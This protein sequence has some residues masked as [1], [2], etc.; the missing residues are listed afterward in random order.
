M[1]SP[2]N[3]TTQL[4]GSTIHKQ[5][6][7]LINSTA[8]VVEMKLAKAEKDRKKPLINNTSAELNID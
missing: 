6:A 1:F 2:A 3:K 4:S 5:T 7:G 8:A